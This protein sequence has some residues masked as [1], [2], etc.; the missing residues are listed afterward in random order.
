[1]KPMVIRDRGVS[2]LDKQIN[3]FF[4]LIVFS[5]HYIFKNILPPFEIIERF[6][7]IRFIDDVC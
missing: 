2:C 3:L 1:L 6:D 7:F 5:K 4:Y